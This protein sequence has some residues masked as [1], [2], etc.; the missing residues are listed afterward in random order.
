MGNQMVNRVVNDHAFQTAGKLSPT[1][2]GL[3][4]SRQKFPCKK[5]LTLNL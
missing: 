4:N 3:I 1:F 5:P 2:H